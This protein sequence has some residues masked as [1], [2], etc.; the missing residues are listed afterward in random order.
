MES[1][2]LK[3]EKKKNDV[4]A[5]QRDGMIWVWYGMYQILITSTSHKL[6]EGFKLLIMGIFM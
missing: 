6:C 5:N 3:I 4:K 1:I 2:D